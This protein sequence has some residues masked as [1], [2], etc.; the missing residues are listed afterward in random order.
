MPERGVRNSWLTVARK[1]DFASLAA[2]AFERASSRWRSVSRRSVISR[3]MRSVLRT[4][5]A[6]SISVSLQEN[7][8]TPSGVSIASSTLRVPSSPVVAAVDL[9]T[10]GP[11]GLSSGRTGGIRRRA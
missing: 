10:N 2:S 7:H 6:A 4:P 5:S 8:R 9:T 1:R 3:P 11:N